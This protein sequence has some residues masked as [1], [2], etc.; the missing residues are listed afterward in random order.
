M[1]CRTLAVISLLVCG[2]TAPDIGAPPR[3]DGDDDPDAPGETST[4]VPA[5]DTD[6]SPH[7]SLLNV[8]GLS[9]AI[10]KNGTLSCTAVAGYANIEEHRLVEPDTLFAW[11]SVSKTV[12]STAAMILSDEGRLDLDGDIND[13]LP[14]SARNPKC[15]NEPITFRQLLTH[16]SS[17][18]DA[19]FYDNYYV[20]GD[21]E[22]PLGDFVGGYVTPGS[23]LYDADQNFADACP[24][25]FNDYS[26]IAVGLLGH[27]IEQ[28]AGVPFD[29]FCRDR[30]FEPL[31]MNE[32]SFHLANLDQDHI[33]MPYY[34]VI[35]VGHLGFPTYPDGL[36]RTSVPQ[37]ARV[38][39]M[40]AEFGTYDGKRILA[41]A[42]ATEMRRVQI[43]Q[44]DDTQGL[45]WYYDLDGA[46][47]GHDG[48]DPGTSSFMFFDPDT[49]DGVL[50]V[51][52]GDWWADDDDAEGA[53][54]LLS[55]LFVEARSR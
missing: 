6:L 44:L 49:G 13:A 50:L 9:A 39:A 40:M 55:E 14:F 4:N 38:L 54:A 11:A 23:E 26:N 16:T 18:V 46:V 32:S 36:L 28:I 41:Q 5:C 31:G 22:I 7:L 25:Q 29:Q 17:I 48:S 30:I 15:P 2:C 37:L 33:A 27:A 42:T 47:L 12:T 45:I 53:Y 52:N 43:P 10:V 34:G 8:P 3:D 51:G 19:D 24:G 21:S 1:R 35:P 20:S